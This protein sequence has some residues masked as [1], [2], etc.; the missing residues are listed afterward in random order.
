MTAK[1]NILIEECSVIMVNDLRFLVVPHEHDST[2][3]VSL[4]DFATLQRHSQV[5][6]EEEVFEMGR[7][8]ARRGVGSKGLVGASTS[9]WRKQGCPLPLAAAACG[10]YL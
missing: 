9:S 7:W 1:A 2:T 6:A 8:S 3:A 5:A 4:I 10:L